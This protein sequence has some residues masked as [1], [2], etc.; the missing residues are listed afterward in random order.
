MRNKQI[1][2]IWARLVVSHCGSTTPK[3][4]TI[5][6]V[7]GLA[8]NPGNCSSPPPTPPLLV[9][10][11]VGTSKLN[12]PKLFRGF[13]STEKSVCCLFWLL[14]NSVTSCKNEKRGRGVKQQKGIKKGR[15]VLR[16][17]R[18]SRIPTPPF[19]TFKLVLQWVVWGKFFS[20]VVSAVVNYAVCISFS[21]PNHHCV[22]Q[23]GSVVALIPL[24]KGGSCPVVRR[25]R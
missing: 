9:H 25:C 6:H 14:L 2:L 11:W 7:T 13:D 8:L 23:T 22:W 18:N 1:A 12:W 20:Q 21:C 10:C 16:P 3:T 24:H 19:W 4:P 17:G 5:S 15:K